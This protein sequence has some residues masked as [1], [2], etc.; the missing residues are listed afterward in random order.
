LG[1]NINVGC[2]VVF[3]NYDGVKKWHTN[4]GD[5]AFIG[6]NSNIVAPVEVADHSFIAAGSTITDDVPFHGM[7]IARARQTTKKD[8]W[9][10][11]PLAESEEWK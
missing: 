7:A 9:D 2:G 5:E 3:V 6:S 1:K 8:Y 4:V 11:L 10:R